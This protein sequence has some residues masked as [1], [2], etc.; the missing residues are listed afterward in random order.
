MDV[1]RATMGHGWPFVAC[2][3]SGDGRREPRRSRGRMMGCP[4][5][6][7]LSLGQARES[8]SPVR[9]ETATQGRR[10]VERL[11][12]KPVA[13]EDRRHHASKLGQQRAAYGVAYALDADRAEVHRQHIE[14]SF[15]AAL[16]GRGHQRG[17]AV[18]ALGLHGFDQHG[19]RHADRNHADP[20]RRQLCRAGGRDHPGQHGN[21]LLCAGGVLRR[22]R[23]PART[24]RRRLRAAGRVCWRGGG[25]LRL[26]LVFRLSV[27]LRV[28]LVLRFRP[29]R[30]SHFL[31]LAQEK[32]TKEKGT[33]SSGPGCA[34]VP[35]FHH[36]SRGTP[37]RAIHGPSWL[38][39]HPCRSTPYAAISLGLLKGI[40]ASSART[41]CKSKSG[42]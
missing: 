20:G 34:G 14:G 27:R 21:Y 6:W 9:G 13:N 29:L 17:K 36:H 19:A 10:A 33:P 15:R 23:H 1:A 16:D 38:S 39:R 35:S 24:P 5:L 22:G 30:A 11:T 26:L 12:E 32:V 7:L 2:P 25:D 42:L 40:L 4:S 8:D 18:D 3:W 31:L 28:A 37:R 41:W